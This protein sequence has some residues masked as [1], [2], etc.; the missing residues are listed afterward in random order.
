MFS[1]EQGCFGVSQDMKYLVF[2]VTL[3]LSACVGPSLPADA[4]PLMQPAEITVRL[5]E[6]VRAGGIT[7]RPLRIVEDSRCPGEV[8]CVWAGRLVLT[9]RIDGNGWSETSDVTT[10]VSHET[11]G[12]TLI[13]TRASPEKKA[14]QPPSA[15]DYVFYFRTN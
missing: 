4:Y 5:Q 6:T 9:T 10:G 12:R 2:P 14:N 8:Q 7:I 11:H 3:A 1:H 13:L 15:T